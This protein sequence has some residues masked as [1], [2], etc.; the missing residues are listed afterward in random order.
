[1]LALA[2]V[3]A[4]TLAGCGAEG[5]TDPSA[6][7]DVTWRLSRLERQDHTVVGVPNPDRYTLVFDEGG[8]LAVRSDCNQ[9]GGT[10]AIADG[11]FTVGSLAC[12]KVF[13][14][15]QSLHAEYSSILAEAR[16]LEMDDRTLIV[17]SN[18]GLLRFMR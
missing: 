13:C 9:C 11:S 15:E 2:V 12:T 4:A 14:G 3:V 5:V 10:Y 16:S 18:R 6:V 8:S 17:R 1:M 7:Q